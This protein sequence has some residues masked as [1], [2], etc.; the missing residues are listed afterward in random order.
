ML[1]N[2]LLFSVFSCLSRANG[3]LKNRK[4]RAITLQIW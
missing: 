1:Q 4:E 3:R 2:S